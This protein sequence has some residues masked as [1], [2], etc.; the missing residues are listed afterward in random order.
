M[1]EAEL[2]GRDGE[3]RILRELTGRLPGTGGALALQGRPG[4]GKSALLR[5]AA[6]HA[7]S[8]GWQVIGAAGR[9]GDAPFSGLR[10]LLQPVLG[11]AD[12]L[13][14]GQD[15]ALRSAFETGSAPPP[16]TFRVALAAL[17]LIAARAA[18]R[19]V[20][21]IADDVQWFDRPSQEVLAFM[22]R[23]ADHDPVVILAALRSGWTL[24]GMPVLDVPVLDEASARR[25]LARRAAALP[26]AV[27]ER[28]LG[29]ALGNPLALVELPAA[30][31]PAGPPGAWAHLPVNSALTTAFAGG[32][33]ALPDQA[34]DAL[35]IAAVT[36][37][38]ELSEVLAAASVLT[39]RPVPVDALDSAVAARLIRLDGTKVHFL[40][41]VVRFAVLDAEAPARRR[42]AHAALAQVLADHPDRCTWHRAQSVN[43]PDDELADELADAHVPLLRSHGV[44]AAIW[45]L[46][47]SAQLTTDSATRG[48]RLLGAAEHAYGLGRTRLTHALIDEAERQQL[49]GTDR[50]KAGW[51]RDISEAGPQAEP[52]PARALDITEP[53]AGDPGLALDL[54]LSAAL[55]AQGA[56]VGSARRAGIVAAADRLTATSDPRHIAALALTEPVL[57]GRAVADRLPSTAAVSALPDADGLRLLGMAAHAIGDPIRAVDL[58]GRAEPVFRDQ[59][60][61]GLLSAVL[62]T[63]AADLLLLGDWPRAATIADEARRIVAETRQPGSIAALTGLDAVAAGLRGEMERALELADTVAAWERADLVPGLR[64]ARGH[65]RLGAGQY[66]EAYDELRPLFDQPRERLTWQSFTALMPFA[67][68]A[69]RSGARRDAADVLAELEEVARVTPAP[70]LHV[71]L[72]YARAVL[73]PESAAEELYMAALGQDLAR[74]PLV[75]ARTEQAYGLWLRRRRQSAEARPMLLAARTT[76]ELVGACDWA[77]HSGTQGGDGPLP[78]VVDLLSPREKLIAGLAAEGLSNREM[79]ERLHLSPRTIAAHLY[80]VFPKLGI[81]SRGELGS[82]LERPETAVTDG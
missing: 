11:S 48:Q 68:A 64:L 60:R 2:L 76:F 18:E 80:R 26:A 63:Q 70:L 10:E 5:A 24:P 36:H 28:M 15:R 14:A 54:L 44:V 33:G 81:R 17:N 23:R 55:R 45:A 27:R 43:G 35:V 51:L 79:A 65:A 58:L 34:R 46:Q 53:T 67:T 37:T 59:G 19:P 6:D 69:D 21:L 62:L 49:G 22:A 75:K 61:L 12:S 31:H 30:W 32:L 20:V 1:H 3:L 56:D 9:A 78:S 71:Q 25:L 40:H 4:V 77:G 42:A 50:A 47:R 66:T 52:V 13:P 16:E 41:P 74:W 72:P 7:R 38:G 73:A 39:R 57:R 29:E 8:T 82:V